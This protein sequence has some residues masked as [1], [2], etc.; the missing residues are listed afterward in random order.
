[1]TRSTRVES[2]PS[3]TCT[4]TRAPSGEDEIS[5]QVRHSDRALTHGSPHPGRALIRPGGPA[6][7]LRGVDTGAATV[8]DVRFVRSAGGTV[9][10]S[11]LMLDRASLVIQVID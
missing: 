7:E 4:S 5:S 6:N 10:I 1:M 2:G 3:G 9:R 8:L 11:E